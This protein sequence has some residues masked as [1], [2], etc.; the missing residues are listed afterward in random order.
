M[1]ID[2]KKI[3]IKQEGEVLETTKMGV[4]LEDLSII[5]DMLS[6]SYKDGIGSLIREVSSNSL[7][8]HRRV[9]NNNPI[10]ISLKNIEG[11][12]KFI[13]QDFGEGIDQD[14]VDNIIS[15]YLK[16]TKKLEVDSL[17]QYG[18]GFKAPLS[19]KDFF[20]FTGRK[21]GIERKWM[22]R[23]GEE[24]NE[25]VKIYE[26]E[27][28]EPNGTIVEIDVDYYDRSEFSNKI[29]EQLAY[30][31]NIYV[32]DD[33]R[34]F[35][36]DFKIYEN[37]LF[38]YSEITT[39]AYLHIC[40]DE[41]YY[42]ID[43]EK[44]G[45]N[46]IYFPVALNFSLTDGIEP[47]FNR[48]D[49]KY[50]KEHK[51][52]ILKRIKEVANWFIDKYN[53]EHKEYDSWKEAEPFI[54]DK[55]KILKICNKNFN[56]DII[57]EYS[58][59]IPVNL[60]I[61]GFNSE[62]IDYLY[63]HRNKIYNILNPIGRIRSNNIFNKNGYSFK[64]SDNN[65]L[66]N[67]VPVGNKREYLKEICPYGTNFYKIL[68]PR[69]LKNKK[70]SYQYNSNNWI[71]TLELKLVP[72]SNWRRL[73]QQAQLIEQEVINSCKD[74]RDFEVPK[75]F[76][77]N[78]KK[79]RQS[80]YI[81]LN[82]EQG[83]ITIAYCRKHTYSDEGVFDKSIYKI[84]DLHKIPYLTVYSIKEDKEKLN[85]IRILFKVLNK[86]YKTAI[87]G[88]REQKHVKELTN[89]K[90]IKE[91]MDLKLVNKYITALK[92]EKV[93][94]Q[95]KLIGDNRDVDIIFD[96]IADKYNDYYIKFKEYINLNNRDV[97]TSI[98]KELEKY[99]EK[100]NSYDLSII[101]DIKKVEEVANK[102][103][104]LQFMNIPRK[105]WRENEI[106]YHNNIKD[107]RKMIHK[108][109][110]FEKLYNNSFEDWTISPPVKDDIIVTEIEQVIEL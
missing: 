42:S 36:N 80:T 50:R 22:M 96:K 25:I 100:N 19:Y 72:K 104:F 82:K 105:G 11:K 92:A 88:E 89:F 13:V 48:E 101:N 41:V 59:K 16:S 21:D 67:E 84:S 28:N 81:S 93:N 74:Y 1:I 85:D 66:V 58:D 62:D 8:S 30:F 107:F 51:E 75:E 57:S 53:E 14:I 37:E 108:F 5:Q 38:K 52:I 90:T 40:L 3:D 35:Y 78:R 43:F 45:I 87:I 103:A 98:S 76:L 102:F 56:I 99:V 49:I 15:Q 26:K 61:K 6:S 2:K 65:V 60:N 18:I 12:W 27:T 86:R 47:I 70:Y 73:I 9:G 77:D 91:F 95:L 4:Y 79:K 69:A 54:N 31:K 106:E 24:E 29:R 97:E 44:L 110:L 94:E 10:L 32:T 46:T 17:G 34:T 23:K 63:K 64:F 7:D 33:Y 68:E 39:T 71:Q 55:I 109:L 83:Q 20:T